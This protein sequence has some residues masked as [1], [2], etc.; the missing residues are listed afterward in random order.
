MDAEILSQKV[1]PPAIFLERFSPKD[2]DTARLQGSPLSIQ[3]VVLDTN[4]ILRDMAYPVR[5]G[6]R[7]NLVHSALAGSFRLFVARHVIDEVEEK[8]SGFIHGRK[9]DEQRA[10]EVWRADYLPL[11]R[12]VDVPDDIADERVAQVGSVDADD[13]PTARLTLLIA[14]CN[15]ISGDNALIKAGLTSVAGQEYLDFVR[16]GKVAADGD[17]VLVGASMLGTLSLFAL[18]ETVKAIVPPGWGL[19][20]GFLLAG[21]GLFAMQQGYVSRERLGR[22]ATQLEPFVTEAGAALEQY[23]NARVSLAASAIHAEQPADLRGKIARYLAKAPHP[24]SGTKIAQA[25]SNDTS[26]VT[27]KAV[28]AVLRGCSA[29]VEVRRYAWQLGQSGVET[30]RV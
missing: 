9:L 6:R 8:L 20:A 17:Q 30:D 10:W 26:R 21:A 15:A 14:P 27:P 28:N 24:C 23:T 12:V 22:A 4:I 5:T 19:A 7:T 1:V 13:V 2:F 18:R 3:P 29:F 16:H 11:L 25:I